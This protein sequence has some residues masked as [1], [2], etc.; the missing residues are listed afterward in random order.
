MELIA[1]LG[2]LSTC[3]VFGWSI[4][5]MARAMDMTVLQFIAFFVF[6]GW[7]FN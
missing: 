7:L 2:V 6:F 5:A 1:F 3:V 4:R